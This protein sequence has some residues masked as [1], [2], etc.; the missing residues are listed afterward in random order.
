M[1][2]YKLSKHTYLSKI[3]Q[4]VQDTMMSQTDLTE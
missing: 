4:T 3:R 2:N 1:A